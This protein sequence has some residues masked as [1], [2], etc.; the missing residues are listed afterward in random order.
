MNRKF[1]SLLIALVL[2]VLAYYVYGHFFKHPGANPAM[3]GGAAPVSVAIVVEKDTSEW[4]EFPGRL[5][6]VNTA[7]IKPR[8]SGAIEKIHFQDGQMVKRGDLLFTID[9]RPYAADVARAKGN[10][11]AANAAYVN[12][13]IDFD[14][15]APLVETGNITKREFDS[16]KS[17]LYSAEGKMIAA[18]GDLALAQ[19]NMDYAEIRAP[20]AG[21]MGRAEITEGNV[22]NAG[23]QAPIIARIV[24]ISPIY[25]SFEMDEQNF[26]NHVQRVPADKLTKIPVEIG[27]SNQE[28]TPYKGHVQAFDNQLNVGSGT[29]RVR[30]IYQNEKGELVPGLFAR[31]RMGSVDSVPTILVNEKAVS[32]DQSK[33][34]VFVVGADNK[35]EYREVT[36]GQTVDGLAVAKTGLKAGDKVVVNGLQRVRPGAPVAP[37]MVDMTT[38]EAVK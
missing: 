13:K 38:L 2:G 3:G 8:V 29:I 9:T 21:K 16:R 7:E 34:F 32:T 27:L 17:A 26:L 18:K 37:E 6:A 10:L 31:V 5:E 11:A 28:G 12:A 22:V 20:F 33:K 14:R 30:A 24:A 23:L 36:I 25:A 19:V 1:R 4:T 35:V 15:A